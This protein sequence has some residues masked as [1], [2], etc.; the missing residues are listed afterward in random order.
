MSL[1]LLIGLD[2]HVLNRLGDL[3]T[4]Q[5]RHMLAWMQ[6]SRTSSHC[7]A[8]Y[9]F[10]TWSCNKYINTL[11]PTQK[12]PL[13][14]RRHFQAH[15]REWKLFFFQ[16]NFTEICSHGSNYQ[17]ANIGCDDGLSPNRRQA[18]IWTK[19]GRVYIRIHAFLSLN[20]LRVMTGACIS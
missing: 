2:L 4:H 5:S 12:W 6:Q 14:H 8:Q 15:F 10:R 11:G 3:I 18:I 17:Y 1:M 19:C 16:Y 9:T 7:D 13:F 20:D